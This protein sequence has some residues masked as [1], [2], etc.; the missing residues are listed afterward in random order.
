MYIV[1]VYSWDCWHEYNAGLF[2]LIILEFLM[3]L[4]SL[5]QATLN[6]HQFTFFSGW[7]LVLSLA[8]VQL[9]LAAL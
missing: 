1:C 9:T 6:A 3:S 5:K 2:T 8:V 4:Q 7:R